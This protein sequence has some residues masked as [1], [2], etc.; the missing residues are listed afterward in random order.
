MFVVYRKVKGKIGR[1]RA[2]LWEATVVKQLC[3]RQRADAQLPT[4]LQVNTPG[5]LH[6]IHLRVLC[7][8]YLACFQKHNLQHNRRRQSRRRRSPLCAICS[9]SSR[10]IPL[11]ALALHARHLPARAFPMPARTICLR[12]FAMLVVLAYCRRC[13]GATLPWGEYSRERPW[14]DANTRRVFES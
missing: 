13:C 8:V 14:P 4:E 3:D 6:T 12:V 2:Y 10:A 7:S 11:P 5:D 9:L 1:D